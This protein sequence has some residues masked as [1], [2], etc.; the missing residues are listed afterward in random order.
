MSAPRRSPFVL[1][2][3]AAPL[4]L[5]VGLPAYGLMFVCIAAAGLGYATGGLS[6]HVGKM[7]LVAF[8]MGTIAGVIDWLR[9]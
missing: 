4:W 6:A 3:F 9:R 5:L 1:R 8:M 7:L 2:A